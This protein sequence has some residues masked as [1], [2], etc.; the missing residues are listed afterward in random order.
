MR[1]LELNEVQDIIYGIFVEFDRVC[2]KHGIKYSMEGGTLLGAVKY[3]NFVPWDDDIDVIML[4]SEY[5]K[6]LSVAPNELGEDYFL[7]SYNNVSEFPLNYAKLC[8]TGAQIYN[9]TYSHLTKMSHGIFMDIFPIDNVKPDV[10]RK[11]CSFVGVFT[12]A[13]KIKLGIDIGK[14]PRVKALIYKMLSLLPMRFLIARVDKNCTKY[15]KK[16]T[17]YRYE[18]CNSNRKFKPLPAEI[19]DEFVELRFRDGSFLAVQEYDT[20]LRSQFGDDYMTTL[21]AEEQRK[22]SHCANIYIN[23]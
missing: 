3:N 1:K 6:F 16:E 21:P 18:V 9:Y 10:L 2:R 5:E 15:N 19:Y 7:Q 8:Y 20:F 14:M 11:H 22:P 13:R 17:G 4:R 12:G 23:E